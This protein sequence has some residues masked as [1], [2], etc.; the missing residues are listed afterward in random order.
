M[1]L[2]VFLAAVFFFLVSPSFG[3]AALASFFGFS[4]LVSAASFLGVAFFFAGAL[5]SAFSTASSLAASFP[6]LVFGADF[7]LVFFF[8]TCLLVF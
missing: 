1:S 5:V 2:S 4:S 3:A 7:D 8:Q 6:A